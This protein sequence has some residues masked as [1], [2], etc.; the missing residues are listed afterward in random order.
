MLGS[1]MSLKMGGFFGSICH[2]SYITEISTVFL[3]I[4]AM[5]ADHKLTDNV[6]YYLNGLVLT[7][8]FFVFRVCFYY[9][10][11]FWKI[12]DYAFYRYHAF[13]MQYPPEDRWLCYTCLVMYTAMFLLQL[14]WFSKIL[15]GVLI[16]FGVDIRKVK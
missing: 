7:W 1:L 16:A 12:L 2:L 13:W 9:Y 6:L 8:A 15:Y 10:M 3:N 4:R 14:V 11:I 5:M